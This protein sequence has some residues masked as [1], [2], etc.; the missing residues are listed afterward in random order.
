[1]SKE[2]L[3]KFFSEGKPRSEPFLRLPYGLLAVVTRI[4]QVQNILKKRLQILTN[5]QPAKVSREMRGPEVGGCRPVL[6]RFNTFAQVGKYQ[7]S[8]IEYYLYFYHRVF[9]LKIVS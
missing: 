4:F 8:N 2:G 3:K 9:I 1:M 7:I 6:V 5:L